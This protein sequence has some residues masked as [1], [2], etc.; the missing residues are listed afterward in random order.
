MEAE[1][2]PQVLMAM[3]LV[4]QAVVEQVAVLLE[5]PILVVVVV[6][7]IL[8]EAVQVVQVLLLFVIQ[9][10]AKKQLVEL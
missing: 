7:H 2:D 3:A 4:E 5:H 9:A 10:L 1:A 6:V 8:V